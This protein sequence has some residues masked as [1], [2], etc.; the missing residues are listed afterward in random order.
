MYTD[1]KFDSN[2]IFNV[3]VNLNDFTGRGDTSALNNAFDLAAN[4][5]HLQTKTNMVS[6]WMRRHA[7]PTRDQVQYVNVNLGQVSPIINNKSRNVQLAFCQCLSAVF[8]DIS[9]VF[10]NATSIAISSLDSGTLVQ[11]TRQSARMQWQTSS[12][13]CFSIQSQQLDMQQQH[14]YLVQLY[15]QQQQYNPQYAQYAPNQQYYPQYAQYAPN[16]QNNLSLLSPHSP[17]PS[18]LHSPIPSGSRSRPAKTTSGRMPKPKHPKSKP[19]SKSAKAADPRPKKEK[20]Q[21]RKPKVKNP[22]K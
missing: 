8:N 6:R 17:L 11:H 22:K 16:Q 5:I 21:T 9:T 19:K 13:A 12:S 2:A 3:S 7:A 10:K 1:P 18:S 15:N 14:E 4:A 20:K